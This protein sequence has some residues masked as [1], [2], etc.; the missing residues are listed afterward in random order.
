MKE[1]AVEL[2]E[3]LRAA[4]RP[5]HARIEQLPTAMELAQGRISLSD[6]LQLLERLYWVHASFEFVAMEHPEFAEVWP[7]EATRATAVARDLAALGGEFP[8]SPP[9]LV[10]RWQQDLRRQGNAAVW[11][12]VGY[13]LEGSRM[14]S[15]MLA[16]PLARAFGVPPGAGVG[17]DYH[18]DGLNDPVGRWERVR[19]AL[20]VLDRGG[21]NRSHVVFGAAATFELM[22]AIHSDPVPEPYL[23]PALV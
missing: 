8:C 19:A 5:I 21:T 18:R 4:T 1:P 22:V 7:R 23:Q 12:G 9:E 13:V 6:Y 15:R 11:A 17:L 20:T 16:G 2:I 10:S 3:E 14:G